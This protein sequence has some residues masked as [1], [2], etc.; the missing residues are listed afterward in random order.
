EDM[1]RFIRE[2]RSDESWRLDQEKEK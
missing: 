2:M 1:E